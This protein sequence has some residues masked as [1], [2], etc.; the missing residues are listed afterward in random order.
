M[1][2][3]NIYFATYADGEYEKNLK[4]NLLFVKIFLKPKKIFIY[5]RQKIVDTKFYER[6]KALLDE[7]RGAG[8]YAW[9]PYII[10]E[11]LNKI[12]V[13]DCLIYYDSGLGKRYL[14]WSGLKNLIRWTQNSR[15]KMLPGLMIPEWGPNSVWT[16][17]DAF[18]IMNL[19]HVNSVKNLPQV[20]ATFSIWIKCKKTVDFVE[21]WTKYAQDRRII[22]DDKN[23]LGFG[24]Y[25]GFVENRHD[26]S[27]LSNLVHKYQIQSINSEKEY[28]PFNKSLSFVDLYFKA[29]RGILRNLIYN[30]ILAL[31]R[32]RFIFVAS[33][34]SMHDR[35]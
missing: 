35:T 1:T 9:K 17:R 6:N 25:E 30:S 18:I 10:Q 2:K 14:V 21:E 15:H 5:N 32:K 31:F 3:L 27:I 11:S 29:N 28:I 24:N 33:E 34:K 16:K 7:Q 19:D 23:T 8:F 12:E 13:D 26:Q 4:K 20:Q 22:S